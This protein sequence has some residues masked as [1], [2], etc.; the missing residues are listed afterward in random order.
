MFPMSKR[1]KLEAKARGKM[2]HMK[3]MQVW[4]QAQKQYGEGRHKS[5]RKLNG[6]TVRIHFH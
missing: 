1:K 6:I 2:A 5:I 4:E 3:K